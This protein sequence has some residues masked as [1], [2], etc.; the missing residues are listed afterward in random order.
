MNTQPGNPSDYLCRL[1]E[2]VEDPHDL[3]MAALM[4]SALH[5]SDRDLESYP[6]H[7]QEIADQARLESR[8]VMSAGDGARTGGGPGQDR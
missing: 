5:H 7:L 6:N 4:L 1:G 8:L 3:A 2:T